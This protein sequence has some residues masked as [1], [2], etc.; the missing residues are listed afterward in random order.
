[1]MVRVELL[2]DKIVVRKNGKIVYWAE[3]SDDANEV[4]R[5]LRSKE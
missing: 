4:A 2:G 3:G 1:M 5:M